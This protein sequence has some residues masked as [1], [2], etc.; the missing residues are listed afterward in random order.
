M[1]FKDAEDRRRYDPQRK[2]TLRAQDGRPAL[3]V[4]VRLKVAEDVE[5][6]LD[7]AIRTI[8]ADAP[9][10][11]HRTAWPKAW[12]S[13]RTRARNR[14]L[15]ADQGPRGST[16][17]GSENEATSLPDDA[18]MMTYQWEF[19]AEQYPDGGGVPLTRPLSTIQAPSNRISQTGV[20]ASIVP[21]AGRVA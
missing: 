20:S 6:L 4:P 8:R 14:R 16:A 2:R 18:L 3:A 11:P 13:T 5:A 19:A 7:E 15:D 17:S 1:P 21:P 9:I 12:V 10:R